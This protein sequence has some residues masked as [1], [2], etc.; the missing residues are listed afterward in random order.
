ME[1]TVMYCRLG[2]LVAS[3]QRDFTFLRARWTILT[4]CEIRC[5]RGVT[6]S[7]SAGLVPRVAEH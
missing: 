2:S 5:A 4:F 6:F 3:L 1:Q 7:T